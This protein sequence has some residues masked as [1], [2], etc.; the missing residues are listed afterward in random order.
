MLGPA[1]TFKFTALLVES[2]FAGSLFSLRYRLPDFGL[3]CYMSSPTINATLFPIS[4]TLTF[5]IAMSSGT[6][7]N[8]QLLDA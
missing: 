5:L 7:C 6:T 4:H 1:A 2:S 8:I 3:L